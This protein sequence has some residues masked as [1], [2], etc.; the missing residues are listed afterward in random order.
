M[1][2]YLKEQFLKTFQAEP[3]KIL[4]CGGRF[5]ILGNHTDHNHGLCIAATCSLS[6]YG[7]FKKRDDLLVH[8]Y[9]EGFGASTIDLSILD[10]RLSETGKPASLIRG[11]ASYLSKDHKYGGL[12]IYINSQI[13][14]GAGVSS[15]AAF[16]LLIAQAINKLF[17]NEE[18]PLLTLC[19]ASQYAESEYY[20]KSCGLLDQ[21]G[22]AYGGIVYIDFKDVNNPIVERLK[23]QR[24]IYEGD[25]SNLYFDDFTFVI[26]NTGGSHA[27]LDAKYGSINKGM[28]LIA[29]HY[30][31]DY[32]RDVDEETFFKDKQFLYDNIDEC[33]TD[34]AEHFF[35]ENQRVKTAYRVIKNDDFESLISLMNKSRQSSADLLHNMTINHYEGSP[36]EACDLIDQ[37]SCHRAGVKINGGGFAG[38]VIA[39]IPNEILE[40][41]L[42]AVK[43]K[44]G[45]EN[46]HIVSIRDEM[47]CEV[48]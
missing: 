8:L 33:S 44:Y 7:A 46:V 29:N 37:V 15:S 28:K 40:R 20:G 12:D 14:P 43:D 45:S 47:P 6:I 38:S 39:L 17:N 24:K 34:A 27:G 9:S 10:K 22:V 41:V 1:K 35:K 11:I 2:D 31:K 25:F 13:P 21:I 3:D 48:K 32:L 30:G 5:E 4:S 42:T 18:I 23:I 19:K 26:V 36:L 16:E